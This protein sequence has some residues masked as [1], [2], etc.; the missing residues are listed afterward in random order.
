M[1]TP[2]L[3][4]IAARVRDRRIDKNIT[5][6]DMSTLMRMSS[7]TY[8]KIEK[9]LKEMSMTEFKR[10]CELLQANYGDI[11]P[12]FKDLKYNIHQE[13]NTVQ[14]SGTANGGMG[15]VVNDQ[16]FEA[17]RRV[18]EELDKAHKTTI[19]AQTATIEALQNTIEAL[20]I[21]LKS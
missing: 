16:N 6:E 15:I 8:Q 2:A 10:A 5:V 14:D 12:D 19:T 3:L 13:H 11:D 17:E 4:W 9:G 21:A 1:P 7:H 18:W 20:K